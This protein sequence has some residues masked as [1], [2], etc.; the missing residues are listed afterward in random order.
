MPRPPELN[1]RP[2][3]HRLAQVRAMVAAGA[4]KT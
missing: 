3:Q 2:R 1:G 4:S